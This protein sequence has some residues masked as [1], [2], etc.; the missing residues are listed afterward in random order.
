GESTDSALIFEDAITPIE[1]R[2]EFSKETKILGENNF[3]KLAISI[4]VIFMIACGILAFR[5]YRRGK[6]DPFDSAQGHSE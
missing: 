2:V 1:E 3:A 6:N 5:S 4:G